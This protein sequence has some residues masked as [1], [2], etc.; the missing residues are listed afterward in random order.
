MLNVCAAYVMIK[1]PKVDRDNWFFMWRYSFLM[2]CQ[3]YN[4]FFI[5]IVKNIAFRYA[6]IS[7]AEAEVWARFE[8]PRLSLENLK[9]ESFFIFEIT[10]AQNIP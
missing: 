5:T 1:R 8:K 3:I 6:I 7:T 9:N 2:S 4:E 10:Y